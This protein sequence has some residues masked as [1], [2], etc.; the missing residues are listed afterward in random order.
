MSFD[1]TA[2]L[3]FVGLFLFARPLAPLVWQVTAFT[4]AHA[5]TLAL[6][7]LE[8]VSLSMN[9]VEPLIALS[10]VWIAVENLLTSGANTPIRVTSSLPK[11]RRTRL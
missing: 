10:I 5:V 4:V 6:G 11:S 2:T 1:V 9:I 8:L 3:V 7:M